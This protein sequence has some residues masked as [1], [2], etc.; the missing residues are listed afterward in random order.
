[1]ASTVYSPM[2]SVNSKSTDE[3]DWYAPLAAYITSA[4]NE[5]PNKYRDELTS[6]NRLRQDTRGAG[7]DNT[8]R[9][10]LYRYYSQLQ[11]LDLR[12]PVG[13]SAKLPMTFTW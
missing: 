1:M 13:D 8:G 11:L 6:F 2:L 12:F 9:D 3:A 10:I 5:D 7:A 4:H